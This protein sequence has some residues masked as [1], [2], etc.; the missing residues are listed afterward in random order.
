MC[1]ILNHH[2]YY[3]KAHIMEKVDLSGKI[4]VV[5]GGSRGIGRQVARDLASAGA[6]V[7]VTARSEEKLA[8]T[9]QLITEAGGTCH[10]YPMDVSDMQQV[11]DTFNK[12]TTD[13]GAVDILVNNAGIANGGEMPWQQSIDSWWQVME[14]NVKG[15]FACSH[16]VMPGMIERGDGCI[17][18]VGSYVGFYS[19]PPA[20][21][22]SVSKAALASLTNN[23]ATALHETGVSVFCISPGLVRTDMTDN[24]NFADVPDD[25][26]IPIE[27]SGALCVQ[28]ASGKADKLSGRFIHASEDDIDEMIA[29]ADEII[30]KNSHVLTLSGW[31]GV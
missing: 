17:I 7:I 9:V 27:K 23:L 31:D 2:G 28:L 20:T 24:P 18:N 13:I 16:A 30:E 25:A 11:E 12:I 29:R 19:A 4:A 10:A 14:V 26:W 15:V 3:K 22:Y 8:E 6:T 1:P 21:A 5:T